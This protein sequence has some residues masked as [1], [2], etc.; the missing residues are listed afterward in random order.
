MRIFCR[1]KFARAIES[2]E[3]GRHAQLHKESR[4]G[5]SN[6][7]DRVDDPVDGGR[8]AKHTMPIFPP[9]GRRRPLLQQ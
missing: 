7:D 8:S 4:F 1:E 5:A 2:G 3:A 6:A 9:R